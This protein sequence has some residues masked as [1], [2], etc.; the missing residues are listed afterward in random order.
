MTRIADLKLEELQ[1]M[2]DQAVERKLREL[3]FLPNE[4]HSLEEVFDAVDRH[5][6]TPPP[7]SRSTLQLLREDRLSIYDSVYVALA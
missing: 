7:G 1:A 6:W 2:I 3:L 5:R 4:V